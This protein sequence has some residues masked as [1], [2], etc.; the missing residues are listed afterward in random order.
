MS[1]DKDKRKNAFAFA[2][3]E[4]KWTL[5]GTK[6]R[7]EYKTRS[8]PIPLTSS[9]ATFEDGWAPAMRACTGS[10]LPFLSLDMD[11]LRWGVPNCVPFRTRHSRQFRTAHV[12]TETY[13]LNWM[14]FQYE[15]GMNGA[16]RRNE[17]QP[18]IP[19]NHF[20]LL[21]CPFIRL[22]ELGTHLHW[23]SIFSKQKI[24]LIRI[25]VTCWISLRV[26]TP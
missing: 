10:V 22:N 25:S 19:T 12:H 17:I 18:D 4:C 20:S 8:L 6:T 11:A 23:H 21:F 1:S 2:F 13:L 9:L 24:I 7:K 15:T 14:W 26:N 3:A 16:F 5:T